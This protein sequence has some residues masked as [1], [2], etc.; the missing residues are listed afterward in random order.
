[1]HLKTAFRPNV[2][3]I[4]KYNHAR[5]LALTNTFYL[6]AGDSRIVSSSTSAPWKQERLVGGAMSRG[7]MRDGSVELALYKRSEIGFREE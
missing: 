3:T 6:Q 7:N 4:R 1:M 2:C 5:L